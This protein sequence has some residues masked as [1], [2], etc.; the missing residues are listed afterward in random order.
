M[1]T[2]IITEKNQAAK[3]IAKA[4][5]VP[6][7]I[8]HSK[9]VNVFY[10]PKRNAYVIPLRGHLLS[11]KN[12]E[13]YQSWNA[14]I[15]RNILTDPDSI[16]K[17]PLNYAKPY[18]AVLKKYAKI[19]SACVIGTDA[20]VEGCNIGL[21]DALPYV[22]KENSNIIVS[23][24]WL[25][26]LQK[27][28]IID[29]FE[30]RIRPKFSWAQAAEARAI[31]DALIG[32]A[33]TR[34]IT[35]AFSSV[36]GR[37]NQKFISIG[38][39]QTSLLYLLYLRDLSIENFKPENYFTIS[40]VHNYS[41]NLYKGV[42]DSNPFK[43]EK[44][45]DAKRIYDL[46][47]NEKYAEVKANNHQMVKRN[48][49][50]PLNTSKALVLLTKNLNISAQTALNTMNELYLKKIITYPRTDSDVYKG[51]FDHIT[52][53]H[54]FCSNQNYRE[55]ATNLIRNGKL[56]PTKGIKDFGDHPPIT[57]LKNLDLS[58]SNLKTK[59]EK[60]VY[61][62]I[63]RHYL[64]LFGDPAIERKH[65]VK[66]EIK[67]EPF[68]VNW[69]NL[70]NDGF[71]SIIPILS[72]KYDNLE[73]ITDRVLPIT[74]ISM[75]EKNTKPAPRYTEPSILKLMERQRLGTKATR[76]QILNILLK[77][78]LV[79][80]KKNR[81]F[82]S[83]LG[84][85]LIRNL[86]PVWKPFLDPSF[87]KKVESLLEMIK[88]EKKS[89]TDVISEVRT[90]FLSLFDL[91]VDNEQKLIA[92]LANYEIE[93][94]KEI[95][96]HNI[97]GFMLMC[98]NCSQ[99][100]MKLIT[101]KKSRFFACQNPSCKKTLSLPKK[102]ILTFLKTNCQICNFK[103]AKVTLTKQNKTFDYYMCP[104]CWNIALKEP[105]QNSGFCNNCKGF[106]IENEKCVRKN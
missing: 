18:I 71:L 33:S 101:T 59:I 80:K 83:D 89:S 50:A 95:F 70:I 25:S 56:T 46:I 42:H 40:S 94:K 85:L 72:P 35:R 77:R 87:T 12:T 8:K 81:Y 67:G 53:V 30:I 38:R 27:K 29:K 5:G 1:S 41:G 15:P 103:V 13:K 4:L 105:Q 11:Y 32:F 96:H 104:F 93:N 43:L 45:S 65:F 79:F 44:V 55:Y 3:A 36:L 47:Q 84:K 34:E 68:N 39:V 88:E 99:K 28:E 51:S 57:P 52:I 100:K 17:Y 86:E 22:L 20:D 48:P 62:I 19:C 21:I 76:P 63:S 58:D 92:N 54:Q 37:L 60:D 78:K 26:S 14:S 23:Q 66:I 102:G 98:P 64:S 74:S 6:T 69:T 75:E 24:L 2:L 97:T 82:I 90:D 49:P 9:Y 61:D 31:L 10:L 7:T 106:K 91:F 16:K 73:E